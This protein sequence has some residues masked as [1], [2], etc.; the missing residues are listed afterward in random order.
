MNLR[1]RKREKD[2]EGYGFDGFHN[3]FVCS[4][5]LKTAETKTQP[6]S[7]K[8]RKYGLLGHCPI[9]REGDC[10]CAYRV[11]LDGKSKLEALRRKPQ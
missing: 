4:S 11:V 5:S 10:C 9:E 7:Q 3:V 1:G 8:A 2:S 6:L